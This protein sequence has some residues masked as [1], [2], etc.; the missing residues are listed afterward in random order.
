M[1]FPHHENELAQSRAANPESEVKC[2]MHNG[3][4][5]NNGQKMAKADKNFFTIR[6]VRG[7]NLSFSVS[8]I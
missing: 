7:L 2:W 3:F 5:N 1:I 4:V 6:D 8:I